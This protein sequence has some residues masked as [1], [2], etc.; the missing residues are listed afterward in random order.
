MNKIK[1]CKENERESNTKEKKI[2]QAIIDHELISCMF[3]LFYLFIY[4][5][6]LSYSC[7][8][9]VFECIFD[10]KL[11][12]KLKFQILIILAQKQKIFGNDD[13]SSPLIVKI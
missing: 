12:K 9:V 10:D 6:L 4:L 8:Y 13:P 5:C 7:L 2:I 11:L 1:R 3:Y